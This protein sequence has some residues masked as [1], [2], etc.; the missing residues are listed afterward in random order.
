MRLSEKISG[1]NTYNFLNSLNESFD[2]VSKDILNKGKRKGMTKDRAD[3]IAANIGRKKY[4]KEKFQKMAQ[5]GKNEGCKNNTNKELTENNEEIN[6]ARSHKE[7]NEK[8]APRKSTIDSVVTGDYKYGVYDDKD[9]RNYKDRYKEPINAKRNKVRNFDSKNYGA[10]NVGFNPKDMNDRLNKGITHKDYE[11]M[12][13][14]KS[15]EYKRLKKVEETNEACKNKMN[16]E[17]SLEKYWDGTEIDRELFK[18]LL[19]L[20]SSD[21]EFIVTNDGNEIGRFRAN[22]NEEAKNKFRSEYV[23]E[24]SE[25]YTDSAEDIYSKVQ[26][27]YSDE[28]RKELFKKFNDKEPNNM[29]EFWDWFESL[30]SDE[31]DSLEENKK[32][33][34]DNEEEING[35]EETTNEDNESSKL[36]AIIKEF[37]DVSPL[38]KRVVSEIVEDSEDYEGTKLEKIQKRLGDVTYGGLGNGNVTSLIYYKDT[39]AFYNEYEDDI[40]DFVEDLCSGGLEPLESLKATCGEAEVIMQSDRVKNQIVWM[41]YEEIAYR[42]ESE[43]EGIE[44]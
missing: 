27:E 5:A 16:E 8:V 10:K 44:E 1:G 36:D 32:L 18:V 14:E 35:P 20:N 13:N 7:D 22:S 12:P 42:L 23:T 2:T 6:E 21:N 17:S 41:V 29:D 4:G 31:I 39:L 9:E 38:Y 15:T 25:F 34:E 37:E 26:N 3:A 19:K 11:K 33:T 28:Q 30:D 24:S 43:L 40:F